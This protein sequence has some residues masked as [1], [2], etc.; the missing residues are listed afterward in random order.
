VLPLKGGAEVKLR[1]GRAGKPGNDVFGSAGR[2][3]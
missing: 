2:E 3:C 1:F